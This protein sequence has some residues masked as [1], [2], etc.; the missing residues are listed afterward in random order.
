MV[1][2]VSAPAVLGAVPLE[3]RQMAN[4]IL[5]AS[6]LSAVLSVA[7]SPMW[8]MGLGLTGGLGWAWARSAYHR[9][10]GLERLRAVETALATTRKDLEEAEARREME[11]GGN[12]VEVVIP[13]DRG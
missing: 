7:M 6:G 5:L 12:G 2:E 11:C 8:L 9:T 3:D 1:S 4:G 13:A 10:R